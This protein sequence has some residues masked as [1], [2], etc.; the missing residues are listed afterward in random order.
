MKGE[1]R[2]LI[3]RIANSAGP[4][5]DVSGALSSRLDDLTS[6]EEEIR[7]DAPQVESEEALHSLEKVRARWMVND[8]FA[9]VD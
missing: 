6:L 2:G 8:C 7:K 1:I 3:T 5:R 4:L 9:L